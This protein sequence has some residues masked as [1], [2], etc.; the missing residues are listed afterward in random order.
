LS[1]HYIEIYCQSQPFLVSQKLDFNL[2]AY[3]KTKGTKNIKI[4]PDMG[5]NEG[6]PDIIPLNNPIVAHMT[7]HATIKTF[8]SKYNIL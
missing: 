8:P 2:Q 4:I 5:A 1:F 7:Q 3:A 6:N